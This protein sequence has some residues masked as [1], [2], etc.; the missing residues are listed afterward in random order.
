MPQGF[1]VLELGPGFRSVEVPSPF[2]V[3]VHT[4]HEKADVLVGEP[5]TIRTDRK[6]KPC[7]ISFP[8]TGDGFR[9][10]DDQPTIGWLTRVDAELVSGSAAFA[11]VSG[12]LARTSSQTILTPG[13]QLVDLLD[14]RPDHVANV[15]A[16]CGDTGMEL[17]VH[18][19]T[20]YRLIGDD[21]TILRAPAPVADNLI[22]WSR[23]F[24]EPTGGVSERARH[25][26]FHQLTEPRFMEW[27]DGLRMRIVPGEQISQA[28][29]V[30]G[31]YEPCTTS[32]LRRLLRDGDTF[33]DVGA[34]VGLFTMLGSRWVG[35]TGRVL[36]FEPSEREFTRL[37]QHVDH[38][39]LHNV[40]ALRM[41]VGNQ[42][43]TA[44][45]RV[46]DA[47]H[48]GLNTLEDHFV[49][50]AVHEAYTETVPIARLDELVASHDVRKV[51]VMKVDVE[52]G[53]HHVIAGARETIARDRPAVILEVASATS[54]PGHQ[55]RSSIEAFFA[56]LGYA[57]A[58]VDGET[59]TVRAVPDLTGSSENF[60]AASR[61]VLDALTRHDIST[62]VFGR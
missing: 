33:V 60:V 31:V 49:Y 42:N 5:L 23:F 20:C 37:R 34:N 57:F 2:D 59:G 61:D 45:L 6:R 21:S 22:R 52:G 9:A 29:F 15:V 48:S 10:T 46:A 14:D 1:G 40:Q 36:A 32:V 16:R 38:N 54:D 51:D 44:L 17:R 47:Q 12:D 8:A 7:V 4:A 53:E 3:K 35:P 58:V 55:G 50:T 28:V 11:Y 41:A 39:G 27:L 43:G 25:L 13:K 62:V 56:S 24:G 26:R 30:S 19:F 18:G